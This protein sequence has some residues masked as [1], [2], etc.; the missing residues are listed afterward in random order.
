VAL[1][2]RKNLA[3]TSVKVTDAPGAGVAARE[4]EP[5]RNDKMYI[6]E[7][8]TTSDDNP[9]EDVGLESD[10]PQAI[11][12]LFKERNSCLKRVIDLPRLGSSVQDP[13]PSY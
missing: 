2:L 7:T 3:V 4:G 9:T 10:S 12:S 11:I 6:I 8:I 1:S 13:S 5:K